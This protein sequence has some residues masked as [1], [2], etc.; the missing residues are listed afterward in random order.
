MV[1]DLLYYIKKQLLIKP[2]YR[3]CRGWGSLF[4]LS[5][6][7]IKIHVLDNFCNYSEVRVSYDAIDDMYMGLSK[8]DS[9][10]KLWFRVPHEWIRRH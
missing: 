8:T 9:T 2:W 6:I 10:N 4:M 3:Y 1:Y 7:Y 5:E